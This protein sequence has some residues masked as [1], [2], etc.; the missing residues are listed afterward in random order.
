MKTVFV[1]VDAYLRPY[2][3]SMMEFL[4][5]LESSSNFLVIL[6]FMNDFLG[7]SLKIF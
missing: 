1:K 6:L 7:E 5:P 3:V 4:T 2:Q